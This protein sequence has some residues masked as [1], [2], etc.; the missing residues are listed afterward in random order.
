MG[1]GTYKN[2]YTR[3]DVLRLI[4]ENGDTAEGLDL[5]EKVFEEGIDLRGLD[6]EGIILKEAI[7]WDIKLEDPERDDPTAGL[8]GAHLEGA[9]LM[10]AHLEGA[11][12]LGSHFE[13]ADLFNA[14]LEGALLTEVHLE[15]T[16]LYIAHLEGAKL[17]SAHLEGAYLSGVKLSSETNLEN[18]DWGDYIL[19]E[20]REGLFDIVSNTYRQLKIWYTNAG[21]HDIAAKFYY[22]EKEANRKA[23]KLRSTHWNDRLS[24][25]FMRALFG[26]GERWWRVP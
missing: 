18:V 5:S 6:L 15:K 25:E 9:S 21:C 1:D 26:Y 10:S 3:E 14:H 8:E 13:G 19:G 17:R 20:E 24:V 12:I 4:K 2:P 16:C 22:R 7:L 23:F 11:H